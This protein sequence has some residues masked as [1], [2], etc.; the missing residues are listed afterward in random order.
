L[1]FLAPYF[2]FRINFK[3]IFLRVACSEDIVANKIEKDN[4]GTYPMVVKVRISDEVMTLNRK[5]KRDKNI[6]SKD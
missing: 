2:H 5:D 4:D 1:R 6:I 3:L